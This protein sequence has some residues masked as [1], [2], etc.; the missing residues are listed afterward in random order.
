MNAQT[1]IK[2]PSV[3]RT[4]T[5]K[6]SRVARPRQ[7]ENSRSTRSKR[8]GYSSQNST[9]SYTDYGQNRR[10]PDGISSYIVSLPSSP[11]NVYVDTDNIQLRVENVTVVEGQMLKM[12]SIVVGNYCNK[13]NAE[14]LYDSCK[15][16]GYTPSIAYSPERGM[17]RVIAGTTD[18][19][20]D[21]A[22][23]TQIL[24]SSPTYYF[25][26]WILYIQ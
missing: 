17:Y 15:S 13:V 4:S 14:G 22:Y 8:N 5:G 25:D 10:Q 19:K 24:K 16:M 6:E 21:V 11:Q 26:S 2:I 3:A 1:N 20:R 7:V 9:N 23:Y 18:V 12:Y